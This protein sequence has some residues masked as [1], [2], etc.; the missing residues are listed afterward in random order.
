MQILPQLDRYSANLIGHFEIS[1]ALV[2]FVEAK[3]VRTESFGQGASGPA[4]FTGSTI[5]GFYE[6]P[7]R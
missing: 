6:Q 2:P 1:E 5:D 4:F 3:Y 7:P